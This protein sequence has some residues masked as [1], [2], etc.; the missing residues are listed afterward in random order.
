M[1]TSTVYRY[2]FKSQLQLKQTTK[3]NRIYFRTVNLHTLVTQIF[4]QSLQIIR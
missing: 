1:K 3:G 4:E 2:S